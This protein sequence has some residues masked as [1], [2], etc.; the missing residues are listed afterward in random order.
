M[1]FKNKVNEI[2]VMQGV[3][4]LTM[5]TAIKDVVTISGS[6][7]GGSLYAPMDNKQICLLYTSPSPRD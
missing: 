3:R 7:E 2:E 4:S 1:L 5:T 6:L